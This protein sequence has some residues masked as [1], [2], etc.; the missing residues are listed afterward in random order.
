VTVRLSARIAG[1]AILAA[2]LAASTAHVRR[3]SGLVALAIII[4]VELAVLMW[5]THPGSADAVK[6]VAPAVLTGVTAAAVWTALVFVV[7]DVASSDAPAFAAIAGVGIVVAVRPP[8][9]TRRRRDVVLVASATTALLTFVAI[10]SLLPAFDGFVP[11]W[12]PPTYTDVTRLV[13]PILEFAIFV[14]LTLALCADLLWV[15]ARA[16]RTHART[17][18]VSSDAAPNEMVVLPTDSE[19]A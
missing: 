12:H 16:R 4:T 3:P 9:G 1:L 11:N 17:R 10:S 14:V 8:S 13:D 15:R 19:P 2:Q 5:S 18:S 6:V 7:P